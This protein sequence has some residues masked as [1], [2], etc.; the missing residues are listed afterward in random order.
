[1]RIELTSC[2]VPKTSRVTT[3]ELP[4]IKDY[5]QHTSKNYWVYPKLPID[6]SHVLDQFRSLTDGDSEIILTILLLDV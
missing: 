4:Y 5:F 1:M 3:P 2:L 6:V